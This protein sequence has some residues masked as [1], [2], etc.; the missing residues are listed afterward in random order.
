MATGRTGNGTFLLNH[1]PITMTLTAF[2]GNLPL[3]E[4]A[5]CGALKVVEKF[6]ALVA[7]GYLEEARKFVKFIDTIQ[8]EAFPEPLARMFAST[9]SL[10][11]S[12]FTPMAAVAGTFSDIAVEAMAEAGADYAVANNGGDIAYLLPADREAFKVGIISNL[13]CNKLTHVMTIPHDLRSAGI[14]TSGFGGRSLTRGIASA[15]TVLAASSSFADAAA[16]SIANATN[17]DDHSVIRCLACELDA[18]TDIAGLTVTKEIGSLSSTSIDEALVNGV[19]RAEELSKNGVILGAI[20]FVAGKM[21][22]SFTC[23][24]APFFIEEYE[25]TIL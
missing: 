1:G 2:K 11:E 6:D 12:F 17:C 21:A 20:L 10:Q 25:G 15:V 14:A 9:I 3:R 16:T 18:T 7:S 23:D 19:K 4:A 13:E 8:Q 24:S 5:E 22:I